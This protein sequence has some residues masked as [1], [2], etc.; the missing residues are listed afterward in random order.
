MALT[1]FPHTVNV[2]RDA[3]PTEQELKENEAMCKVRHSPELLLVRC[4]LRLQRP[5]CLHHSTKE[6]YFPWYLR[7]EAVL[8]VC[9]HS[10]PLHPAFFAL[11][12]KRRVP[13]A[14]PA[15][16]AQQSCESCVQFMTD[17]GLYETR[18]ETMER[19]DVLSKLS[20]IVEKW[21]KL[22]AAH[23]GLSEAEIEDAH[24]I[25]NTFG[26]FRLQ[27][28][29]PGTMPNF[30]CTTRSMRVALAARASENP[31]AVYYPG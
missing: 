13:G 20:D 9:R 6:S 29:G 7:F 14:L 8:R 15:A 16:T 26:S 31:H 27:V 25:V 4:S 1:H 12:V 19:I 17:R 10:R 24:A 2:I 18:E 5:Q 3:E 22:A 23:V 28:H 21:I 30:F 11:L